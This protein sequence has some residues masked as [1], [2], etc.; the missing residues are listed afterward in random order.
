MFFHARCFLL[1][2]DTG[3][4]KNYFCGRVR[5]FFGLFIIQNAYFTQNIF[6]QRIMIIGTYQLS[7]ICTGTGSLQCCGAVLFLAVGSGLLKSLRLRFRLSV[8]IC[9][10]HETLKASLKNN[11]I[12]IKSPAPAP[13][14]CPQMYDYACTV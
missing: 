10:H 7:R 9:S 4:I 6:Y 2:K 1:Y 12:Q 3:I 11:T 13:Q 14:H 5:N 8:Q